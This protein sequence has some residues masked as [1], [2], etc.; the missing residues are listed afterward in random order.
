MPVRG[1]RTSS[2]NPRVKALVRLRSRRDREA[3]GVTLV[4]GHD[5]LRL[6]LAAGVVPA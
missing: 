5:E 4:E 6:A 1:E 3:A 2:A